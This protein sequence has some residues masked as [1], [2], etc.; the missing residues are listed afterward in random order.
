MY[1]HYPTYHQ[2]LVLGAGESGT[3]AALLAQK[4]GM[5]V[6]VSDTGHIKP[7]YKELLAT[8]QIPY[9]ESGH[10]ITAVQQADLIVV[11]P[12]IPAHA[13]GVFYGQTR[14]SYNI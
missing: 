1:Q 10:T 5:N 7:T 8:H 6:L 11:S 2:I 3:G 12:G 13:Q 4:H 14:N 9:E